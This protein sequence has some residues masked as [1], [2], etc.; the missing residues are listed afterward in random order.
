MYY[1]SVKLIG[2]NRTITARYTDYDN[3]LDTLN[4]L[5][6]R[7]DFYIGYAFDYTGKCVLTIKRA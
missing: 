5:S 7:D 6:E 1:I 3:M 4:L 2:Y